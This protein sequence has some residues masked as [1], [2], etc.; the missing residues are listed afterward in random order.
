MIL[1]AQLTL[2]LDEGL[3]DFSRYFQDSTAVEANSRWPTDSGLLNRALHRAFHY[4]SKLGELGLPAF[5]RW[6]MP[7]WLRRLRR[8]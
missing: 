3:D 2:A 7:R 5:R 4:G 8:H 1:A 6:T